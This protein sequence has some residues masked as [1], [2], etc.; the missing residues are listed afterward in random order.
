MYIEG[1]ISVGGCEHE[2]RVLVKGPGPALE[3]VGHQADF[4]VE[5]RVETQAR[6]VFYHHG[7]RGWW[8][9]GPRVV[10]SAPDSGRLVSCHSRPC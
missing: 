2:A 9:L 8:D 6:G 5:V 4:R 3:G 10:L 7:K 1:Q